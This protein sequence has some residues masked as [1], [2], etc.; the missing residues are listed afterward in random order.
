MK[1]IFADVTIGTIENSRCLFNLKYEY[2]VMVL[3]VWNR[4]SWGG[5]NSRPAHRI[6]RNTT[7]PV[8]RTP[9]DKRLIGV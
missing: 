2:L 7:R 8:G 1:Q 5:I 4:K 6:G 3:A 9:P